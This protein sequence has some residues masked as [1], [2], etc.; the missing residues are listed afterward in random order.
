MNTTIIKSQSQQTPK[1]AYEPP[2]L[3]IRAQETTGG[4]N[5]MIRYFFEFDIR[6]ASTTLQQFDQVDLVVSSDDCSTVY[7][8]QGD[9]ATITPGV[10]TVELALEPLQNTIDTVLTQTDAWTIDGSST[11]ATTHYTNDAL[12]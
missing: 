6:G 1:P 5:R 2:L 10:C 3:D 4:V 11:S 7:T 9:V 8:A 12:M